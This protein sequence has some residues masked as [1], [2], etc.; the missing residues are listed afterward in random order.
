MST[1]YLAPEGYPDNI[2]I[3]EVDKTLKCMLCLLVLKDA[4][5][6]NN[7]HCFCK[8]CLLSLF[9][10]DEISPC[11]ECQEPLSKEVRPARILNDQ[12]SRLEVRCYTAVDLSASLKPKKKKQK[13]IESYNGLFNCC[14]W[15]G[16]LGDLETHMS[17]CDNAITK[18]IFDDCTVLT[19]RRVLGEHIKTCTQRPVHCEW[20][21]KPLR[22]YA[23]SPH[24]DSC[25]LRPTP[26]SNPDC[27]AIVPFTALLQHMQECPFGLTSCPLQ[28]LIGC[29]HICLRCDMEAHVADASVHFRAVAEKLLHATSTVSR[30]QESIVDMQ[31]TL[32]TQR[33]ALEANQE[34]LRLLE[35]RLNEVS[36]KWGIEGLNPY[37][38]LV[39]SSPPFH[40]F[41]HSFGLSLDAEYVYGPT[42]QGLVVSFGLSLHMLSRVPDYI[43]Y[44]LRVGR[45][46]AA[47]DS[48]HCVSY[49]SETPQLFDG[50]ILWSRNCRQLVRIA[51]LVP[52]KLLTLDGALHVEVILWREG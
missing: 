31:V 34:T 40:A 28:D 24:K 22:G 29:S 35:K 52:E 13:R 37:L 42:G 46:L 19:E 33:L 45:S 23:L 30:L 16:R 11:P 3:S 43:G 51:D 8:S 21:N 14:E 38:P 50:V 10:E 7:E 1:Y 27:S 49:S 32:S 36:F 41:G 25:S 20:C 39:Y 6:C 2:F 5:R 17:K 4:V 9:G 18:C 47:D 15:T 26:C 12:I 48:L 44:R